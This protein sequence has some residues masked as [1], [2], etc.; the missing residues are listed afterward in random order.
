MQYG[1]LASPS[2]RAA[3]YLRDDV[4]LVVFFWGEGQA[5][6]VGLSLPSVF[7]FFFFFVDMG[8]FYRL[9]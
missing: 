8:V 5:V 1:A 6:L 7:G 4:C 9:G 2:M 3:F